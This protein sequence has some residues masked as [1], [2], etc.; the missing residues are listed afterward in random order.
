MFQER[1]ASLVIEAWGAFTV[2][3][4]CDG[5]ATRLELDLAQIPGATETFLDDAPPLA[6]ETSVA[7]AEPAQK[8]KAKPKPTVK[9]KAAPKAKRSLKSR[10]TLKPKK[11]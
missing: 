10:A 7:K 6:E 2:G 3:A 8:P 1:H 5:G 4:E 11:K 9:R